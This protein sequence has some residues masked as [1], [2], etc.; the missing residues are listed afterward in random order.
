[1]TSLQI[2]FSACPELEVSKDLYNKCTFYAFTSQLPGR[3]APAKL[4]C[5]TSSQA[6]P[7]IRN[8]RICPKWVVRHQ[9]L[10]LFQSISPGL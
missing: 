3:A 9:S 7:S 2:F 1:M 4:K 5:K 6:A 10:W 8:L